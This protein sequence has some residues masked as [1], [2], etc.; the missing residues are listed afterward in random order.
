[1]NLVHIESRS[2]KREEAAYDF[3]VELDTCGSGDVTTALDEIKAKASHFNII[4]R[5]HKNNTGNSTFAVLLADAKRTR[6][7]LLGP[8]YRQFSSHS[9]VYGSLVIPNK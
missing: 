2:S 7:Y 6:S 1:M 9:H 8:I 4:S 5:D 3:F